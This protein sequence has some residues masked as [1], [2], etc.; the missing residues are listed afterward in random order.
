MHYFTS[1]MHSV[2]ALQRVLH[3]NSGLL[4]HCHRASLLLVACAVLLAACGTRSAA[5]PT[6]RP[7][8]P[9]SVAAQPLRD[10]VQPCSNGFVAHAL[11]HRTTVAELP[12]TQFAGNGAGLAIGDLNDDGLPEIVLANLDG[13]NTILWNQGQLRFR[14]ERLEGSD[15]RAA[16]IV[17]VD[18]DGRL[19][20]VFTRRHAGPLYLHN[21]DGTHFA[22]TPFAVRV[23]V[24]SM[25]WGDLD[26]DNRLDFVGATYDAE[27][28]QTQGIQFFTN[29]DGGVYIYHQ[30]GATFEHERLSDKAQALAIALPD[31]NGDGRPDVL[32][33]NDFA[34]PDAAWQ[35]ADSG[36]QPTQPFA[37]MTENTMGFDQGDVDNSGRL[38]LFATD[39]KP[40]DQS[41][42]T[43]AKWLPMMQKMELP[44]SSTDPQRAENMLQA[45]DANG[46]YRNQGYARMIDATGWSWSGKFGDLDNDGF[47]DLYIV[48]GMISR[49]L[50]GHLPNDELVEPNQ[51]FRNDGCGGFQRAPQWQLGATASG[52]GMSMADLDGDGDLDIV[53]NN[54]Q[55]PAQLF[56]NR[57]CGGTSLE[58]DLRWPA[59]GNTRALGARA[60]LE[61]SSGSYIRDV[62]AISG[63]LSGDSAQL[64][65]GV[66]SGAQLQRLSILWPDGTQSAVAAPRARTRLLITR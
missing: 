14:T 62:R 38:A 10:A 13:P 1:S 43:L 65:F 41:I 37:T 7:A 21:Q 42:T 51:A 39:M 34:M 47:L 3:S 17:D 20:I 59:S 18:G 54:L 33:G 9:V 35:H 4:A 6:A 36:W 28:E 32:V 16:A 61:T 11:D 31:L 44:T 29:H 53:V 12:I 66:P 5:A 57:L 45:P 19:D 64:H 63:Y 50:F 60:V 22:A 27:L 48:N 58:V 25:N 30:R 40:L 56:E 24:Y 55:S 15:S 23:P 2:N 26:G 49:G 8:V 46:R 52:R